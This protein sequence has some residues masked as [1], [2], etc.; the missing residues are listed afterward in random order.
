MRVVVDPNCRLPYITY[1]LQGFADIGQFVQFGRVDAPHGAGAALL[2]DGQR[3][4]LDA[5]DPTTVEPGASE[6]ADTV[7]KVN[8]DDTS[9]PSLPLGPLFGIRY[10]SRFRAYAALP[11]LVRAGA[12]VGPTLAGLR[13]QAITRLPIGAY[14]AAPPTKSDFVYLRARNWTGAHQVANSPRERFMEALSRIEVER[15]LEL[16]DDR[17]PLSE[18]LGQLRRSAVAFNCPAVHGCLGW[19]LGEYLALGKAIISTPLGGRQLPAELVHGEH[20][21]FVEDDADAMQRAVQELLGNDAYRHHLELG[22]AAWFDRHLAPSVVAL[23]I[24]DGGGQP[25]TRQAPPD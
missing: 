15:S 8:V 14:S 24:V 3:I 16:A 1:V 2:I 21:H 6:W 19:K 5:N 25:R 11:R 20:V 18:Y 7:M 12:P 13:F 9:P 4:W 22:A 17:V 10:W 23:R